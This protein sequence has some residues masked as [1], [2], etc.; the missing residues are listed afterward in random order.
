MNDN[1]NGHA[2]LIQCLLVL[3]KL[4]LS[5]FLHILYFLVNAM[6][7]LRNKDKIDDVHK[8]VLICCYLK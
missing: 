8:N 6:N 4:L 5:Y 3:S 1:V 7:Q 2:S